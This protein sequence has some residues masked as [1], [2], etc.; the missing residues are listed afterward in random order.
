VPGSRQTSERALPPLH[1]LIGRL[2]E[3]RDLVD[4]LEQRLGLLVLEA[5]PL[6]GTSALVALAV[7]DV[8]RRAFI[9]DARPA[10]SALDLALAITTAVVARFAP[11][12]TGWWTGTAHTLDRPA[13]RLMG[14]LQEAGIDLESL[15]QGATGSG[16]TQL[17]RALEMAELLADGPVLLVID[18]LD[19]LLERVN[20]PTSRE[21]LGV[22][23][24]D[25]QRVGQPVE[26]L[27]VG[28]TGGRLATALSDNSHPLY[29]AGPK[30]HIRR[31]KPVQFVHDL[32][33]GRPWIDVP[34]PYVGA[35]AELGNG[36]S[37][38]VWRIVEEAKRRGQ[39]GDGPTDAVLRT[40]QAM[41]WLG[42]PGYAQRFRELA[43]L[44]PVAPTI[45]SAIATSVGP[46]GLGLNPKRV[47]DA[48]T[49]LRARGTIFAPAPRRWAVSDPLLAAWARDNASATVRR[50]AARD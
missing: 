17:R 42:E 35:A 32:A 44:H 13:L 9:V 48:V 25:R 27:L 39:A 31:A 12:A 41:R 11:E 40:W 49:R 29:R 26:L 16:S 38:F 8:E 3:H 43:S 10:D 15:R 23:R 28:H 1:W 46:Y 24:A 36:S 21:I 18:H 50:R 2:G 22:L 7:A 6:S 45:V 30:L 4:R 47:H 19:A 20:E 34:V 33:I 37:A 5:D 14:R